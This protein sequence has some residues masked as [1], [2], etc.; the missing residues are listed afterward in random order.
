MDCD[1][2]FTDVRV[3]EDEITMVLGNPVHADAAEQVE[4]QMYEAYGVDK[5]FMSKYVEYSLKRTP[6]DV[7]Q[8][9]H[10]LPPSRMDRVEMTRLVEEC[11]ANVGVY[12][13]KKK[14]VREVFQSE[15]LRLKK[16]KDELVCAAEKKEMNEKLKSLVLH[17]HAFNEEG[18]K[19]WAKLLR[20]TQLEPID[21]STFHCDME[22]YI[23][24]WTAA[25]LSVHFPKQAIQLM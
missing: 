7:M 16:L 22:R 3:D 5:Q 12:E 24:A 25:K 9:R 13:S 6:M 18:H 4:R 14:H 1:F 19:N 2:D 23:R 20:I 8:E 21:S 15:Y 11:V 17:Y 10:L